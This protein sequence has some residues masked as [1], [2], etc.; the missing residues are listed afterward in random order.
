[1]KRTQRILLSVFSG[2]LLS[3]PWLGLP[4]WILFF[5]LFPLFILDKYFVENKEQYPGVSFWGHAFIVTFVWNGVT[6]WWIAYATF[7]GALMAIAVNSFVMSLVLWL[8]HFARRNLKHALGYIALAG[9]W[10]SFEYFHF[11]WDIEW[12]WLTLGN[13][14][15]NNVKIIQW[16]EFTGVF[17]GTLWVL[18]INIL[19]LK[20]FEGIREKV[21]SHVI[22]PAFFILF[23]IAAPVLISL[24]MYNN[25]KE[26]NNPKNIILVQPNI[27]P[28]LEDYSRKAE[29]AKLEKFIQLAGEKANRQTDFIVGPE[30]IVENYKNWNVDRIQNSQQYKMLKSFQNHYPNTELMFGVSSSK[31]YK[32][33][34]ASETARYREG[35]YFDVFNTAVFLQK[36]G[37]YQLY[38]K[39]ILVSGV[40]KVPFLKYFGFLK[41]VFIDLG[42]TSGNL[43]SQDEPS[44]FFA[45]DSTKLAPVICY[46]SVFGDYLTQFVK[47]GAELIFII[48][49]DGWWRNSPGYKQHFSF[50]RLRAIETRRSI[51]R[52]ANTGISGF[53]NQRGDVV[54]H[55]QW[56]EP[57]SVAGRLNTNNK[58]TFYV[59][60]GD[61]I[62]RIFLFVSILLLM[63][64][65]AAGLQKKKIF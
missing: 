44:L 6:T 55:T 57:A 14:F 59:K 20:F 45:K 8:A 54:L 31:I 4:G 52:T 26:V 5:A 1:M 22:K 30:T 50:A 10:I 3:L 43:G 18:L 25:Y 61:F 19:V 60:Y 38:H 33:Q 16:Y 35:K 11:H 12:P 53:I 2:L 15:A 9:L 39:S 42:G 49:N 28:Y 40:E 13:G 58:I 46:E 32:E 36:S 7:A 47:K 65:L 21:L 27:D 34:E 62:A 17:G 24:K 41:N 56:W 51:A 64:L 23:L 29:N 63:Q 37:D 48:T